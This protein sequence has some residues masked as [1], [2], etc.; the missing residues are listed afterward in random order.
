MKLKT[1]NK[2]LKKKNIR[3]RKKDE[4]SRD[5]F[6]NLKFRL[7]AIRAELMKMRSSQEEKL[8]TMQKQ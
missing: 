8:K 2:S 4:K 6:K 5:N 7:N 3:L 1:K